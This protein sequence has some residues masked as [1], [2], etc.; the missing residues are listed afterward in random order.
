[1]VNE[2]IPLKEGIKRCGFGENL[3]NDMYNGILLK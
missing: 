1:M 3:Y 2:D